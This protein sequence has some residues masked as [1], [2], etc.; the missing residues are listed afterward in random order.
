MP[1]PMLDY[2]FGGGE[3]EAWQRDHP[4]LP[5]PWWLRGDYVGHGGSGREQ[6]RI[7][8]HEDSR[9]LIF[10]APHDAAAPEPARPDEDVRLY[11][12]R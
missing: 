8:H 6:E 10:F 1:Y 11:A 3:N 4:G 9:A 5:D 12:K 7:F 2:R